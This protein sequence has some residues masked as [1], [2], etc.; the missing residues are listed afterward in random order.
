M[1]QVLAR[2]GKT[3]KYDK[4]YKKLYYN[5]KYPSSFKGIY[6]LFYQA[7]KENPKILLDDVKRWLLKQDT[8]TLHHY[9]IKKFHRNPFISRHI[10][11]NWQIDLVD[12]EYPEENNGYKYLLMVIDVL[13]KYGWSE[14]L[15]NKKPQS[16]KKVFTQLI[17]KSKRKPK[18][19]TSDSGTE[20]NNSLFKRFL[21]NKKIKHFIARNTEVKASVVE[22][23]NRTKKE[24]I[25][26][27]M[28]FNKTNRFVN[29]L[30]NIIDN[31]NS[32]IH[33]RTKYKPIDVNKNNE[34]IVFKNLYNIYE[35]LKEPSFIVGDYVRIQRIKKTFEKGYKPNWSQELFTISKV[36]NTSPTNTYIISD[37]SGEELLGSFY[38]QELLKVYNG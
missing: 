23:W 27:Y 11:D 12:I 9:K 8:Y 31:Y 6:K 25:Y 22:R 7:K 30:N 10:D 20:F 38:P 26:K 33:S 18:V 4:L 36:L 2:N 13:S 3:I 35:T 29:I 1:K 15:L 37:K 32:T 19:L 24:Q 5:I 17:R 14:P 21:I 28:F 34:H 16:I